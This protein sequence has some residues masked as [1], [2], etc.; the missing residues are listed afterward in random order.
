MTV[1]RPPHRPALLAHVVC[2]GVGTAGGGGVEVEVHG[3]EEVACAHDRRT[4]AGRLLG[5]FAGAEVGRFVRVGNP[6]LQ[7][8]VFALAAYG[9]VAPFGALCRRFVIIGR[10]AEFVV[11]PFG[12]R[13][14]YFGALFE[15]DARHRNNRQ[16]VRRPDARVRSLV[17]TH[18]DD[19]RSLLHA[20]ESRL[21]H[22]FGFAHESH[23]RPVGRLAGVYVQQFDALHG[24]D[25]VGYLLDD[26]HVAPLAEV[27]DTF[28][29]P[30][31]HDVSSLF[32][33]KYWFQSASKFNGFILNPKY[34]RCYKITFFREE[35]QEQ[36][37]AVL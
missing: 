2:D 8:F 13:A 27:G 21:G 10:D 20:A 14:G 15:G 11:Y 6:F 19:L 37:M 25:G 7:P 3:D 32:V 24:G 28:H 12:Q 1:L 5:V 36:Q 26:T 34:K 4:A 18:V 35:A 9:E 17:M 16:H 30:F 31:V 33:F 23:H 22:R 29:K